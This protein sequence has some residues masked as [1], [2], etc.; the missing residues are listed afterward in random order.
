[1]ELVCLTATGASFSS[2]GKLNESVLLIG[3]VLGLSLDV[4]SLTKNKSLN[5]I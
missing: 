3:S 5:P 4:S 2:L 1:M